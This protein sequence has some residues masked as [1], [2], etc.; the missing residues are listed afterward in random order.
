MTNRTGSV[1]IDDEPVLAGVP[2]REDLDVESP[3]ELSLSRD[4]SVPVELWIDDVEVG[5]V[6]LGRAGEAELAFRPLLRDNFGRYASS[7]FPWQGG[8]RPVRS[9]VRGEAAEEGAEMLRAVRE[10]DEAA[11]G[12][13]DRV[14]ASSA[15]SFRLEGTAEN[16]AAAAK[17]FSL[18]E[19]IP[20]CVSAEP[21]AIVAAGEAVPAEIGAVSPR[22]DASESRRQKR[23]EGEPVGGTRRSAARRETAL[24]RPEAGPVRDEPAETGEEMKLLAGVPAAG[25]FYVYSFDGRLL[26]EY[27]VSGVLVR[28]YVY[29]G[30]QLIAEYRNAGGQLLYYTSDQISSTRIVTDGSGTV[31]YA[32]AHEPYG[33]IQKTWTSAYDPALKFSGKPRDPESELDYFGARYYNHSLYRFISTDP[34]LTKTMREYN[35]QL[36]NN[37][38]FSR[39][40]PLSYLEALGAYSVYYL[41]FFVKTFSCSK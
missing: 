39:N 38:A 16:P 17:R 41:I 28:D 13:D 22:E 12:V 24:R 23:W 3:P 14:F 33:G 26:A 20:S 7:R 29:F 5:F 36:M 9:E 34:A 10:E 37:Y 4:A 1:W 35:P 32:A 6:D 15:K 2:L 21:F 11:S 40:S 31:V 19:R 8:W 30:G 25:A 18:P 27:D